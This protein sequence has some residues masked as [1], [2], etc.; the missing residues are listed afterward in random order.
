MT[1]IYCPNCKRF[2]LKVKN[3]DIELKCP[4]CKQIV[5]IKIMDA[6]SDLFDGLTESCSIVNI[7]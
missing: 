7:K 2:L 5:Q 6:K 1:P 4:K 3:A